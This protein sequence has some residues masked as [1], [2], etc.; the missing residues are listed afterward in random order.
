MR[1]AV[2]RPGDEWITWLQGALA[3]R[4]ADALLIVTLEISDYWPRQRNLLGG[5]EVRLGTDYEQQVPWLTSLDDPIQ[6]LQLTGAVIGSDGRALRIGAEGIVA[7]SSN[8]LLSALGAQQLIT[9]EDVEQ[10]LAL[11]RDDLPGQPLA[12]QVA[13]RNLVRGLMPR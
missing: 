6:V 9:D 4:N 13:L 10:V 3:E 11:R 7:R 1:L 2:A 12:W 5:K 8:L